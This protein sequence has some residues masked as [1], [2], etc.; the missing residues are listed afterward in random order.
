MEE[1]LWIM[2]ERE[3]CCMLLHCPGY[4]WWSYIFIFGRFHA[5]TANRNRDIHP[6]AGAPRRFRMTIPTA[7][8]R[9][10]HPNRFPPGDARPRGRYRT[11]RDTPTVRFNFAG[12]GGTTLTPTVCPRF[13]GAAS[14]YRSR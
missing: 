10:S 4:M 7:L 12:S 3:E 13:P 5:V 11:G 8:I 1:M 14:R 2:E 6:R 9:F